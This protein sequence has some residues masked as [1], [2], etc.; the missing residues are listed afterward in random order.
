MQVMVNLHLKDRCI[1]AEAR[2]EFE[3]LMDSYFKTDDTEGE[4]DVQIELLRDFIEE[5]DFS[6]L[7]SSDRRLS[8]NQE[9]DVV[10][11]RSGNGTI[12]MEV[13]NARPG[14]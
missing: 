6:K 4:L 3:R 2:N 8:G 12:V 9:S 7:R 1:E 10:I 11:R 13:V 5:S 14:A